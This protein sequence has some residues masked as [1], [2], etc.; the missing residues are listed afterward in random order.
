MWSNVFHTF[1]KNHM[2]CWRFILLI[3]TGGPVW[4]TNLEVFFYKYLQMITMIKEMW[5]T[6]I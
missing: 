5:E 2:E 4:A 6:F 1:Q 3:N